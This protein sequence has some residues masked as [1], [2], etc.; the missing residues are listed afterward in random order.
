MLDNLRVV[1]GGRARRAGLCRQR[2]ARGRV[3]R[4]AQLSHGA[5]R[6][7][8][9]ACVFDAEQG[10]AARAL[11]A[12]GRAALFRGH[13]QRTQAR[14]AVAVDKALRNQLAE[15][16][17]DLSPQQPRACSDFVEER[18]AVRRDDLEHTPPARAQCN[19]A[20]AL[21]EARPNRQIA[22]R[23]ECD[24]RGA[25]RAGDACAARIQRGDA[26]PHDSSRAAQLIQPRRVVF[27]HPGRQDL[28]FPRRS[29]RLVAFQLRDDA[30]DRVR[31]FDARI[32]RDALPFEEEAHEVARLD[33]FDFLAQAIHRVAVDARQQAPLAPLDF[34]RA[35]REVP[36]HHRAFGLQ[37]QQCQVG[38]GGGQPERRRQRAGRYGAEALQ[39]IAQDFHERGFALPGFSI[40]L[41]R[42]DVRCARRSRKHGFEFRQALSGNQYAVRVDRQARYARRSRKLVQQRRPRRLRGH[43]RVA[44]ETETD[45]GGVQFVGVARINPDFVAHLLNRLQIELAE[46][47][48][49]LRVHPAP[50]QHR[51]RAPF[52]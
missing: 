2:G 12:V 21:R 46:V 6:E 16:V 19:I 50:R 8:P 34:K 1:A 9:T 32:R 20:A 11:A 35:G 40:V 13:E 17:F 49:V 41:R 3:Q 39:A 14:K 36:A 31:T 24:R 44:Q 7:R 10:S 38:I 4:C 45:Q 51:L 22:P 43:F 29:W 15:C 47:G 26:R 33:G 25:H 27:V 23:G 30:C 37:L 42:V 48:R 18:R 52:L 28:R 5:P